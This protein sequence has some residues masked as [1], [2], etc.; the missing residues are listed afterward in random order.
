MKFGFVFFVVGVGIAACCGWMERYVGD[1]Q[2][3]ALKMLGW[4][5]LLIGLI[6]FLLGVLQSPIRR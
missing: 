2:P 1:P 3:E 4:G 5:L 6:L